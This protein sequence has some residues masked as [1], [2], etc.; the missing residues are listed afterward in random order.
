[1]N[2][3]RLSFCPASRTRSSALGAPLPLRH[4]VRGAFCSSWF[5]SASPLPST[6]STAG[7]SALF[8]GFPGTMGLSDFPWPCFTGVPLSGSRRGLARCP[9]QPWDLPA[10]VRG[11]SVHARGLR[12]RGAPVRLAIAAHAASPSA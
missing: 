11:A 9:R 10:S 1:M 7:S 4:C 2:R 5:P 3:C 6:S 8:D 12:P